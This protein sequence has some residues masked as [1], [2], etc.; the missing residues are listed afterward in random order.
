MQRQEQPFPFSSL[1]FNLH[2]LLP[3]VALQIHR[4]KTV[5]LRCKDSIGKVGGYAGRLCKALAWFVGPG[6]LHPVAPGIFN[7]AEGAAPIKAYCAA[8]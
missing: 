4:V 3:P 8:F 2:I 5:Y 6:P 7:S 1:P